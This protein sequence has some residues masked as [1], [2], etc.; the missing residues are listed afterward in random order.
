MVAHTARARC[1]N[2]MIPTAR[3]RYEIRLHLEFA[4]KCEQPNATANA[5]IDYVNC[6]PY[7]N[8]IPQVPPADESTTV[9]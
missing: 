6:V 3:R 5:Q 4:P 1:C 7:I 8:Y 9:C 2:V